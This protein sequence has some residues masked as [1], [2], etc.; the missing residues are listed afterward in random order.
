M[1]GFDDDGQ[2]NLSRLEKI[3]LLLDDEVQQRNDHGE[4][5]Y[6]RPDPLLVASRYRDESIALICALFGYGNAHQIVKFLDS[7]DFSLLDQSEARIKETLDTHYYR[8]QKS[9]DVTALFIALKR[10]KEID[11]I[12]NI[13]YAGYSKEENI[14]DGLWHFIET[15]H[16]L[17][18]QHSQG[19]RFLIGSIP[20]KVNSAGTYKRYMMFLRWMV[21]ED[22]LDMGLWTKIK[23][24]DLIMPLDTHTF[25]VSR[26]LGLLERKS[27]DMKAALELTEQLK[28]FDSEDPVKYDFAIYRLGQERQL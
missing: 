18:P 9:D 25:Q 23:K 14:L 3:K 6:S 22:H 20:K 15:L 7:L 8:F 12:E 5:S 27:Y 4:L 19:Y 11:S 2:S 28:L 24:R 21:R 1:R 26:R 10:L 13:F 16:S 17:Y